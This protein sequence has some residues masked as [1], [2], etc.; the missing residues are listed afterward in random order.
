MHTRTQHTNAQTHRMVAHLVSNEILHA[1][2]FSLSLSL[3]HT[4]THSYTHTHS[5]S[6]SRSLTFC[7]VCMHI[8]S[9][10]HTRTHTHTHTHAHTHTHTH[11]HIQDVGCSHI[12]C[13][14]MRSKLLRLWIIYKYVKKPH[15]HPLKSPIYTYYIKEPCI[16]T[17]LQIEELNIRIYSNIKDVCA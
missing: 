14:S 5:Q 13:D 2:S 10:M 8:Y 7:L 6:L 4:R 1:L 17:N 11:T 3:S 12:K 16:R 9:P 15:M